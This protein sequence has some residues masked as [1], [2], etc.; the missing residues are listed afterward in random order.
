MSGEFS[1]LR[2]TTHHTPPFCHYVV[3]MSRSFTAC[4]LKQVSPG[5]ISVNRIEV[6]N[7]SP[8]SAVSPLIHRREVQWTCVIVSAAGNVIT[9]E[10]QLP[11]TAVHC[12]GKLLLMYHP[13]D[14]STMQTYTRTSAQYLAGRHNVNPQHSRC[15]TCTDA[16]S[17]PT[18]QVGSCNST[19]IWLSLLR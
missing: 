4:R 3:L 12:A 5:L 13:P 10:S 9:I 1:S 8:F 17:T 18:P 7:T 19:G 14:A 16:V 11:E 6:H 15:V 2:Y